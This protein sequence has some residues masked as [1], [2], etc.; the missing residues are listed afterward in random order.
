M[1]ALQ[2]EKEMCIKVPWRERGNLTVEVGSAHFLEKRKW[3][4][5]ASTLHKLLSAT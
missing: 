1:I 5:P 3:G 2:E 4:L